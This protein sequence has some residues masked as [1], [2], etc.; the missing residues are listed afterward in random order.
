MM[1]KLLIDETPLMVLPKL[2][3]KIGLNEAILLQQIH[4]WTA[5]PKVGVEHSG[6]KWI[7]NTYQQ[8]I[9]DNFPFWSLNTL[10][11]ASDNL[12]ELNLVLV[13]KTLNKA[14]YDKTLWYS[15]DYDE[16][17][18]YAEPKRLPKMGR[19][20]EKAT[21]QNGQ[22]DLPKM[23]A[24]I[25]ET[26]Q[27]LLK[28]SKTPAPNGAGPHLE[29]KEPTPAQ[30][31]FEALAEV[32]GYDLKKLTD[33]V[34]GML[35]KNEKILRKAGYTAEFVRDVFGPWWYRTDFRG[36]KKQKPTPSQVVT[37][38]GRVPVDNFDDY[39]ADLERRRVEARKALEA[40]HEAA[41]A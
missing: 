1:S 12:R 23:G 32:C 5:N 19:G 8:W 3:A 15:I 20:S 9:D 41:N 21:A 26:T 14:K 31:M 27:R 10:R 36:Q 11:R 35:N 29:P 6:R 17:E 40:I 18:K 2:A 24:P 39:E 34:R 16:L 4:Y 7:R 37:E 33:P 30:A 25:P 13:T 22:I 38:I 28:D